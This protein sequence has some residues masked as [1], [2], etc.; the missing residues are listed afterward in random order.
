MIHHKEH[1]HFF[2]EFWKMFEI[3]KKTVNKLGNK[4]YIPLP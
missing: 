2:T 4:A 1:N 3:F